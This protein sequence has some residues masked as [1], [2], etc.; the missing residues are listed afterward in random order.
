MSKELDKEYEKL[1]KTEPTRSQCLEYSWA[2]KALAEGL[3]ERSVWHM[4]RHID[5]ALRYLTEFRGHFV[6][7]P[8][9]NEK[10]AA[11]SA[12]LHTYM[13]KGMDGPLSVM[14]YRMIAEN[15]GKPVWFAFC[16]ALAKDIKKM[17]YREAFKAAHL[18]LELD[19]STDNILMLSLLQMWEEEWEY[20][21]NW[22]SP[23]EE[24][25]TLT[26]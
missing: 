22:F 12:N 24:G 13:R 25:R 9:L 20:V 8:K 10:E 11:V 6:Q 3:T 17:N 5:Q 1:N 15:R 2:L 4:F 19:G 21:K 14:M 23:E 7:T 26:L 16:K 18:P